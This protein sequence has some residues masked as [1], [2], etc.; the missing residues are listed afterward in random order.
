ML[1]ENVSLQKQLIRAEK[2]LLSSHL[3]KTPNMES[4]SQYLNSQVL[5][6]E[7]LKCFDNACAGVFLGEQS[8]PEDLNVKRDTIQEGNG[9]NEQQE[10]YR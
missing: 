4:R 2:K 10:S 6:W 8:V 5:V 7:L 9:A 3:K 1:E